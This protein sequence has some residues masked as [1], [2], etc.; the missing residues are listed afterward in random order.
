MER[1]YEVGEHV[2][3]HLVEGIIIRMMILRL[4]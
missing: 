4:S 1:Q 3:W 2:T